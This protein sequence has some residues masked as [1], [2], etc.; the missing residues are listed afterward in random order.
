[1]WCDAIKEH[2]QY[3]FSIKKIDELRKI[4]KPQSN[5][6]HPKDDVWTYSSPHLKSITLADAANPVAL[7]STDKN[8]TG[9]ARPKRWFVG[10]PVYGKPDR[11]WSSIIITSII[12][13]N[14]N[15]K[16]FFFFSLTS[17]QHVLILATPP[18]LVGAHARSSAGRSLR[19]FWAEVRRS[20]VSIVCEASHHIAFTILSC[21]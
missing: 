4:Q 11:S 6:I 10:R 1:M 18:Y 17:S 3:I 9:V 8:E 7:I 15:M 5:V 13:T 21:S 2:L 19:V 12:W 14:S 16:R 20:L